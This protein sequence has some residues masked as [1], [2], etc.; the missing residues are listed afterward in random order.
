MSRLKDF[1]PDLEVENI[2]E[3]LSE[4]PPQK[5]FPWGKGGHDFIQNR[6]IILPECTD[7]TEDRRQALFA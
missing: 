7:L 5:P 2:V 1:R 6:H 3:Q 4:L